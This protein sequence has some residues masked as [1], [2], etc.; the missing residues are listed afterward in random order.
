[1][2]DARRKE[3]EEL[4][5]NR[6]KNDLTKAK[7]KEKKEAEKKAKIRQREE[8]LKELEYGIKS[9]TEDLRRIREERFR[10][11]R[12]EMQTRA[13]DRRNQ[14]KEMELNVSNLRS[15]GTTDK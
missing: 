2:M 14:I 1:M 12:T 11:Q 5:E 8:E 10:I 6:K 13:A 9:K 7:L 4:A 3:D 15:S